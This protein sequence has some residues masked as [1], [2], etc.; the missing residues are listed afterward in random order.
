MTARGNKVKR[1]VVGISDNSDDDLIRLPAISDTKRRF[2]S[3]TGFSGQ[4]HITGRRREPLI[5][6]Q[7]QQYS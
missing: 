7:N 1:F 2:S 5:F 3:A 6:M 4:T